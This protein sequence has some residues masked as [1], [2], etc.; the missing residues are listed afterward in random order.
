[1]LGSID[2]SRLLAGLRHLVQLLLPDRRVTGPIPGL[3]EVDSAERRGASLRAPTASAGWRRPSSAR[4][5]RTA[6]GRFRVLGPLCLTPEIEG[7][8]HVV[9]AGRGVVAGDVRVPGTHP[10]AI[11]D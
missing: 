11:E 3:V 9:V 4:P 5:G 10:A 2:N 6:R 1:M 7:P 8:E